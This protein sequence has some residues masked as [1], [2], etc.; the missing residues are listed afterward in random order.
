MVLAYKN[1]NVDKVA[2]A[3]N[4]VNEIRTYLSEKAN[5]GDKKAA[6]L[7][8]KLNVAIAKGE[9]AGRDDAIKQISAGKKDPSNFILS[10]F[11]DLEPNSSYSSLDDVYHELQQLINKSNLGRSLKGAVKLARAL[12]AKNISGQE[13][14]FIDKI[15]PAIIKDVV[16]WVTMT[17]LLNEYVLEPAAEEGSVRPDK[18]TKIVQNAENVLNKLQD[19]DLNK[20]LGLEKTK[21]PGATTTIAKGFFVSELLEQ[22]SE[23][24]GNIEQF[25]K[26][27]NEADTKSLQK[28]NA[29][30]IQFSVESQAILKKVDLSDEEINQLQTL[31]RNL[32]KAVEEKAKELKVGTKPL[33]VSE[34]HLKATEDHI[35]NLMKKKETEYEEVITNYHNTVIEIFAEMFNIPKE[36]IDEIIDETLDERK[37]R[38]RALGEVLRNRRSKEEKPEPIEQQKLFD[39]SKEQTQTPNDTPK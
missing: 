36:S 32:N 8:E 4:E 18:A 6:D 9:K 27:I 22:I 38:H 7:L 25:I 31:Q 39:T 20:L 13:Q 30:I 1:E 37:K 14:T 10:L 5:T 11:R 12:G 34:N 21:V 35:E 26:S 33:T 28:A 2:A 29:A 24:E 16:A 17:K 23:R 3:V 15:D 19:D